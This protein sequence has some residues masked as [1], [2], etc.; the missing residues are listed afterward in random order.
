MWHII[1]RAR[2]A[3]P[4]PITPNNFFSNSWCHHRLF[5]FVEDKFPQNFYLDF[6]QIVR[7][8]GRC[9]QTTCC[10]MM[11]PSLARSNFKSCKCRMIFVVFTAHSVAWGFFNIQET[12]N[13]RIELRAHF[14]CIR[15]IA[16]EKLFGKDWLQMNV[17]GRIILIAYNCSSNISH[18]FI[19]LWEIVNG[20]KWLKEDLY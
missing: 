17:C 4:S 11:H 14:S 20:L 13:N 5:P 8:D 12:S 6:I 16:L 10:F 1:E 3:S 15:S 18:L 19:C 2:F 7:V 9:L